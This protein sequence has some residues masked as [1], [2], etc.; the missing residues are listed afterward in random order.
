MSDAKIILSNLIENLEHLYVLLFKTA[1]TPEKI[2]KAI[3]TL[4][5]LI[6]SNKTYLLNTK[7]YT[8]YDLIKFSDYLDENG[9]YALADK[10]DVFIKSFSIENNLAKLADYL[11]ENNLSELADIIDESSL[12]IRRA[13]D[14][15]FF[16]KQKG[17]TEEDLPIK[18]LNKISL[19]TRYCP[20]HRGVQAIRLDDSTYQCPIDG[21]IYNYETGYIDYEG[22]RVPGGSIAAQTPTTSNYGGIPMRVY[23]S[24]SDV[25]NRI[26]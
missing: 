15:G 23:D 13:E 22:Q 14:Y 17:P 24:R 19:S 20:D 10:V 18:P 21:K 6:K 8:I 7:S 1:D 26:N 9:K 4:G 25:L 5:E 12:I 3:D 11:D 2:Q 16:P